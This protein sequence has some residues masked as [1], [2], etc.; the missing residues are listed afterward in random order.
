MA[1]FI[2]KIDIG[3]DAMK[4]PRD[5]CRTLREIADNIKD[6]RI[7]DLRHYQSVRDVNGNRIGQFGIKGNVGETLPIVEVD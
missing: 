2:L 3:N 7:N 4:T 5:I 6:A 1:Q